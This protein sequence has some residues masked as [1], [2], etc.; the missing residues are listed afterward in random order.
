MTRKKLSFPVDR[1]RQYLESGPVVLVTS[2]ARGRNNIMTMGWHSIIDFSPSLVGCVTAS[3]N[4]SYRTIRD[5]GECVINLPTANM[6]D[7]VAK[8]GNV[9]GADVDKFVAFGLT[10]EKAEKV[11]APLIAEC[12]AHFECRLH[13]DALVDKYNYFIFEVVAA[14]VAA[15]PAHPETLHYLGDGQFMVAGKTISRRG[16]FTKVS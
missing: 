6:V 14:Q 3:S 8:I 5:T 12:H 16:L 15:R 7:Q 4:H 10:P 9:S 11:G 13:D 1:I 2:Q